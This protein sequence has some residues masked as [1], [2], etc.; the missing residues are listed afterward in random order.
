MLAGKAPFYGRLSL[1]VFPMLLV[2]AISALSEVSRR[3]GRIPLAA[4]IAVLAF[5]MV[6]QAPRALRPIDVQDQRGALAFLVQNRAEGEPVYVTRFALPALRFYQPELRRSADYVEGVDAFERR[7]AVPGDSG[8]GLSRPV[9]DLVVDDM[10]VRI[11]S[12]R[13]WVVTAH[14]DASEAAF[15]EAIVRRFGVVRD[16]HF[17]RRGAGVHLYVR[18]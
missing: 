3:L 16:R 18:P 5:A 15:S 10:A 8:P 9:V 17:Q 14:M 6:W 11:A 12:R 2:L 1:F 7:T 13:F 4:G